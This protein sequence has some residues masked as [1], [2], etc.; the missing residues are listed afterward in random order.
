[1]AKSTD[2]TSGTKGGSTVTKGGSPVKAGGSP[3]TRGE[4]NDRD[5][6][7]PGIG[8]NFSGPKAKS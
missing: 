5:L 6:A 1:M 4:G 3:A 2:R 7:G 8:P